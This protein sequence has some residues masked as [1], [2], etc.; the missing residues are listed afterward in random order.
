MEK[1]NNPNIEFICT[2]PGVE[3]TMPI[4]RSSEYKHSW[5]KKAAADFKSNGSLSKDF[6]DDDS[7]EA[8]RA[9]S[10]NTFKKEDNR[11][12]VKCPAMQ[13]WHNTGWI[14]RLPYDIRFEVITQGEYWD[15]V[16]ADKEIKKRPVSFHL[17]HSFYP[18]FE[19]WPKNTMKKIV[20]LHLPWAARIPKGYKLLL[21]HPMFLDDWRFT[22]CSGIYESQLGIA[23]IGTVPLF[24]HSLEGQH[25]IAAGTPVAQFILIPKEEPDFKIIEEENDKKFQKEQTI[26]RKLLSQGFNVN[27]PQIREFWKKYGW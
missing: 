23:D 17:K 12:T 13:L 24:W 9:V 11:H 14:M 22:V 4:I 1:T 26:T 6:P 18:F 21:L 16:A 19:N 8:F 3:S 15:F 5:I 25:T 20:K 27:Y 7:E 10:N 2:E